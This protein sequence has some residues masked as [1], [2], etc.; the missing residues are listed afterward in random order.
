MA[1]FKSL[2][3]QREGDRQETFTVIFQTDKGTYTYTTSSLEEFQQFTPGSEWTL[4]LNGFGDIVEI[5][6]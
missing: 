1:C 5:Q 3:A 4:V 2:D 6:P